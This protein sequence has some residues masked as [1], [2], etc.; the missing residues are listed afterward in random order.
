MN[1]FNIKEHNAKYFGF[2]Q[3]AANGEW[4]N[5]NIAIK[6][7]YVAGGIGFILTLIGVVSVLFQYSWGFSTIMLG[8]IT[9]ASNLFNLKRIK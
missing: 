6:G 4:P 8:L 1:K 7:S 2:A 9:L 5:K 3:K